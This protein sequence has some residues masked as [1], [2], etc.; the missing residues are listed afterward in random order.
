MAN[1]YRIFPKKTANIIA[2]GVL[3]TWLDRNVKP[4]PFYWIHIANLKKY[5]A[6]AGYIGMYNCYKISWDWIII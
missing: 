3:K 5:L 4:S 1:E 2:K 6:I